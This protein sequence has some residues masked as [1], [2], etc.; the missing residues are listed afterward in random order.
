MYFN[1]L[2]PDYY[3][4]MLLFFGHSLSIQACWVLNVNIIH[5]SSVGISS[6]RSSMFML[7][8]S[9]PAELLKLFNSSVSNFYIKI[10]SYVDVL[11]VCV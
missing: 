10:Y 4:V 5:I 3:A 8:F 9:L 6:A 1:V 11:S 7:L 2:K